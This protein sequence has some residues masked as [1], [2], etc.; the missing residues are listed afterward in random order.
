[1]YM[2][3]SKEREEKLNTTMNPKTTKPKKK[4]EAQLFAGK[5]L[6]KKSK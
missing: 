4:T 3:H 2:Y 1:M 6:K 5:N